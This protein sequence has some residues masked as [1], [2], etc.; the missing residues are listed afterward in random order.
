M[1]ELKLHP[2]VFQ[3][4]VCGAQLRRFE[5]GALRRYVWLHPQRSEPRRLFRSEDSA[6]FHCARDRE[7]P[8]GPGMLGRSIWVPRDD[9][10]IERGAA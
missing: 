7:A 10:G 2:R 8:G 5:R 9:E 6:G 1:G 4:C 3:L